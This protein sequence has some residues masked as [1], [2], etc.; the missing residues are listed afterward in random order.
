MT[1][2]ARSATTDETQATCPAVDAVSVRVVAELT[3]HLGLSADEPRPVGHGLS[4]PAR[5]RRSVGWWVLGPGRE[6]CGRG[7]L[8]TSVGFRAGVE[9]PARSAEC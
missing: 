2:A 1:T 5:G 7:D 8:G 6:G 9:L 4:S 3:G